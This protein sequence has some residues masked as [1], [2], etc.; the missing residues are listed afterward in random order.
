MSGITVTHTANAGFFL[1]MGS[2]RVAVD[3]LHRGLSTEGYPG[4]SRELWER[5]KA[6]Q[7]APGIV[8]FTHC[9]PDHFAYALA[10]PAGQVW[11]DTQFLLPERR[12]SEQRLLTE[13]EERFTLGDLSLRFFRLT[14]EGESY[15]DL[16]H[17][18]MLAESA[19]VTLFSSGDGEIVDPALPEVIGP[20]GVDIAVLNF[21]WL[22]LRGGRK[23][24]QE[25]LRPKHILLNHFP[26]A[27]RD[28]LGYRQTA[29]RA[30]ER[31]FPDTDVRILTEPLQRIIL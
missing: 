16:P 12:L 22:C 26:S 21:P 19:G 20:E 28:S 24:V 13:A 30:A 25:L 11:P 15:R 14:H 10:E 1:D 2:V 6:E 17:Y 27:D 23:V 18:A 3:A 8:F 9:H 4:V 31:F 7:P 29:R 5:I